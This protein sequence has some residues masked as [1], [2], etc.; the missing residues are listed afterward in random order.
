MTPAEVQAKYPHLANLPLLEK[1]TERRYV[2]DYLAK[3]AHKAM[4]RK[5]NASEDK[6]FDAARAYH[7][8]SA[9]L[10]DAQH[11]TGWMKHHEKVTNIGLPK[12]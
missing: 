6:Y 10:V 1:L 4:N 7:K 2:I 8:A 9:V 12:K 11:G 5:L 3:R